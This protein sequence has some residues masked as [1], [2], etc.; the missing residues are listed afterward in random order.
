MD[1]AAKFFIPLCIYAC[2]TLALAQVPGEQQVN[3]PYPLPDEMGVNWDVQN[4]GSIGDGG[5]DQYDGGGHLFLDNGTQFNSPSGTGSFNASRNEVILGP[6]PYNG[7]NVSRR[8]AVNPKLK[9][10]RWAEVLENPTGQKISVALRVYFNMGSSVQIVQ[11]LVEEKK[12]KQMSA[13]AVGD[14]RHMFAMAFAG[15]GAKLVPQVHPQQGSDN[16]NVFY[17]VEVPARETVVI[18]HVQAYRPGDPTAALQF[19]TETKERE[20]LAQL[21][22]ELQRRVANFAGG[23]KFLGDLEVLRG[24]TLDVVEL[25]TGDRMM[26][27]LLESAY[28]LH[29][30]YGDVRLPVDRVIGLINVGTYRPRQLLIT[31][32]GEVFGGHLRRQVLSLRLSSGQQIDVPLAHVARAGYRKRP[33]E[34]EE[35]TFAKPMVTLRTGDRVEVGM[36]VDEIDVVT[37]YGKLRLKPAAIAAIE[38]Q[39]EDGGGASHQIHLTD[40]SRFAGPRCSSRSS[41]R[42]SPS[43]SPPAASHDSS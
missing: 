5:N 30:F 36:P 37:R 38:F 23:Q 17:N 9:F 24:E 33:A 8:I 3:L 19:L 25:R 7:L 35:W 10:C 4:D 41:P 42:R 16:V 22:K 6:F 43:A 28:D 40:G 2:T 39:P 34:P 27:T 31:T 32:D 13:M 20:Y 18:V 26:C 1:V 14:Q 29:T 11:P 15:R 21:P 12:Q